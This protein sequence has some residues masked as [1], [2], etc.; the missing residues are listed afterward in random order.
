MK[1]APH[2]TRPAHGFPRAPRR[3]PAAHLGD[4]EGH[5]VLGA[6][7]LEL[8]HDA[9]ADA[10]DALG[11]QAVHHALNQVD[12]KNARGMERWQRKR[13]CTWVAGRACATGPLL[14]RGPLLAPPS[15]NYLVP[16]G[17]VDEICIDEHL[18]RGAKLGV[19]P[20]E[21]RR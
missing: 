11:V 7:L 19:V 6:E 21:E 15:K 2:Q 3:S 12:L 18:V 9:V 4:L 14:Q 13:V 16:D 17:K 20:E 1:Y 10:G 5:P 8:C